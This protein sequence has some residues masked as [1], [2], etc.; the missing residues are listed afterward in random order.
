MD[1]DFGNREIIDKIIRIKQDLGNQLLI[2]TH[3]Y[4]RREIVEL[5]HHRG[6]SYA[7]ARRA[8]KDENARFI[9]FCGVG[10]MADSAAILAK[11]N[12]VVQIPDP[13][14]GCWL[15]D[16]AQAAM[17]DKAWA[18]VIKITGK[19]AIMPMAYINSHAGVKALC[20][21]H[22]GI[23]CTSS[24]AKKAFEWAFKQKGKLFFI[25]DEHLGR[26][27][28][29]AMDIPRNQILVW[30]PE[31]PLGGNSE[32][33]LKRAKVYLWKGSCSVHTK[34]FAEQ[35][36][37]MRKTFPQAQV[38]VHPECT[39]EV[40]RLADDCGSTSFIARYVTCA[41]PDSTIIVGTEINLIKRLAA[42]HPDKKILP[43]SDAFC[44]NM[45][46]INLKNLLHTL[47]NIGKT[48]VITLDDTVK[49][50][51]FIAL[52]KMLDL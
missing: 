35:V 50:E 32:Q 46:K 20:G 27:T 2:L 29:L 13:G 40:V 15:A 43:L 16:M 36:L 42:E 52:S 18:Q 45:H 17:V 3:H 31:K 8:A 48:N 33:A 12:Q 1:T 19:N 47:E 39:N 14:A 11:E 23:V 22:G 21:R 51:A 49:K 7:L 4:Q 38:V 25:P 44:P 37:S 10:F 6:D 28:A 5:G 24:N 26:N 34:F 9:V 41:P 30:D